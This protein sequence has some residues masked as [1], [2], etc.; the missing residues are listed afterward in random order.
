MSQDYDR[1]MVEYLR[2]GNSTRSMRPTAANRQVLIKESNTI[3]ATIL[4]VS[5][6]AMAR[7]IRYP[8]PAL[9][10]TSSPNTAPMTQIATAILA[11][12]KIDGKLDGNSA[13]RKTLPREAPN[14]RKRLITSRSVERRPSNVLTTIGKNPTR[15]VMITL[16]ASP[17]PSVTRSSGAS[18]GI[19]MVWLATIIG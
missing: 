8:R 6:C 1:V 16:G 7:I 15:A 10:P 12:A 4:G 13:S 18:A 3:A 5:N 9:A 19:G 17:Y 14:E 2:Q 11:P